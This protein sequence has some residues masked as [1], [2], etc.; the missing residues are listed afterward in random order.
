EKDSKTMQ[1]FTQRIRDQF[2]FLSYAPI[3]YVSAKTKEKLHKLLP[4]VNHVAEMHALRVQTPVL[5]DVISD[6]VTINPPPT[7]KGKKLRINYG[8]QVAVKPPTFVLF[9][10][11]PELMHFSYLR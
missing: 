1:Q 11:D 9:V 10:N 7:D 4:V 2:L 6:A 8:T 3:V 5:N